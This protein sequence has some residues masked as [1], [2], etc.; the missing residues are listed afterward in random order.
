MKGAVIA[1]TATPNKNTISTDT[2]TWSDIHNKARYSATNTGISINMKDGKL[3][4]PTP[5]SG[6]PAFGDADSTTKSAIS[7]GTIKI[8]SNPNMDISKLSRDPLGAANA[9]GKIFDKKTVQEKQELANM[10]GELAFDAIGDLDLKENSPEK[11]A[12]KAIFGGIMSH[13]TG[14]SFASGAASAGITQLIMNELANIK[15]PALLQWAT[16]VIGAA[17]SELTG[18][19][20]LTGGSIALSDLRNNY[21]KHQDKQRFINDIIKAL[22]NGSSKDEILEIVEKYTGIDIDNQLESPDMPGSIGSG[23]W[24]QQLQDLLYVTLGFSWDSG[25]SDANNLSQLVEYI[26]NLPEIPKQLDA[27]RLAE[28]YAKDPQNGLNFIKSF[29]MGVIGVGV[30]GLAGEAVLSGATLAELVFSGQI[31]LVNVGGKLQVQIQSF[32]NQLGELLNIPKV[33]TLYRAIGPEEFYKV[34]KTGEFSISGTGMAAKQFG[35]SLEETIAFA[36]R[37]PDIA[38]V[39]EVKVPTYMLN[40]IADLTRVDGFLFKNG[41]ITIRAENLAEFNRIVQEINHVY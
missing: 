27:S 15:D 26:S 13:L 18:G 31:I 34:M 35:L 7:P 25:N 12:L 1:S 30:V 5:I 33:T 28:L 40:R 23:G 11:A 6:M 2:L 4:K 10:F 37:Y 24:D 22:K 3:G 14:E 19:E 21:L 16:L 36:E 29:G 20:G 39:I 32:S 17:I 38:A 9:L 8:R 41:T